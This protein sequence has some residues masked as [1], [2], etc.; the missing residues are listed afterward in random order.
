MRNLLKRN[1]FYVFLAIVVLCVIISAVS[2]A[3][4]T[5]ENLFDMLKTYSFMGIF[6]VGILFVLVSGGID[7]SFT[8]I[9][10]VCEYAMVAFVVRFGGNIVTAFLFAAMCGILLGAI[11]GLIIYFVKIPP[12]ITTIATFNIMFGMLFVVTKGQ[13]VITFPSFFNEFAKINLFTA[14]TADGSP[15]GLSIVVVIWMIALLLAFGVLRYTNLGRNV[16][17]IGGNPVAARR[18][19]INVFRTQL[20]VYSFMGLLSGIAAVV[21][22]TLVLTVVPNSIV[23]KELEVIAAV[24]LGGASIVGGAGSLL[25]TTL[26]IGLFAIVSNGV[27]LMRISSYWYKVFTGLVIIT[28]VSVSAYRFKMSKKREV[29]I[30][31]EEAEGTRLA[32]SRER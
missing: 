30:K 20:F 1:E 24:I 12:I 2:P 9:A 19:G 7:I 25:G 31:M 6:S 29:K 27:T 16:Y 26:G 28:S 17:C 5:L 4:F 8:A 14:T 3:F 21:H 15:Y 10:Q 32:A 22:F 13:L 23:G 18:V 11:N